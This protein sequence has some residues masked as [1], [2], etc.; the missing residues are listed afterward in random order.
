M[1]MMITLYD[2]GEDN[3]TVPRRKS[4]R[5]GSMAECTREKGSHRF[6][7]PVGGRE[8]EILDRRDRSQFN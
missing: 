7:S 6:P 4:S 1:M 8:K 5:K 2:G 3:Q